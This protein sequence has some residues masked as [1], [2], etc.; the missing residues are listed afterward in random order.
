MHKRNTTIIYIGEGCPKIVQLIINESTNYCT[1]MQSEC[2]RR[3]CAREN[4]RAF[5][6]TFSK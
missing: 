2:A 3:E 4:A 6:K 5:F 1:M